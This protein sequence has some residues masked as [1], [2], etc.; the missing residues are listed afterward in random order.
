MKGK[1]KKLWTFITKI[2]K[3]YKPAQDKSW[4]FKSNPTKSMSSLEIYNKLK[5]KQ[6]NSLYSIYNN[7][8]YPKI[9]TVF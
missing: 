6:K 2:T 9:P 3:F 8:I 4:S 7:I 1:K 5:Q